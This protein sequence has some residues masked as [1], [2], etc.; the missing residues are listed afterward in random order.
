MD[1]TWTV[2]VDPASEA[3]LLSKHLILDIKDV[4]RE[5]AVIDFV[6]PVQLSIFGHRFMAVAEQMGQTM[7]KTPISVNIKERLHCSCAFFFADGGLVANA[8]HIPG[9]LGSM[10]D[11]IAYQARLYGPGELKPGDVLLSNHPCSGGTHVV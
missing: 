1:K 6:D 7:Q 2:V 9:H 4:E 5:Q 11:T 8:P 10:S 3:T